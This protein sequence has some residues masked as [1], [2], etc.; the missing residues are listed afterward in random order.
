MMKKHNHR[1][2]ALLLGAFLLACLTGCGSASKKKA[3]V[4]AT[5]S[6]EDSVAQ[7]YAEKFAEELESLSGGSMQIEIHPNSELGSNKELLASCGKGDIQFLV[8][9]T[10]VQL[11]T[12]PNLAVFDLPC[13]F[14]N[15]D[16]LRKKLDDQT[17]SEMIEEVYAKEGYHYLGMADQG[18]CLLTSN[19]EIKK[20][21]SFK[22]LKLRSM[23]NSCHKA[24]WTALGSVPTKAKL[25]QTYDALKEGG[26]DAQES[27]YETI[28]A[29]KF[30]EQQTYLVETNHIP[31]LISLFCNEN[32]YNNLSEGEKFIMK[33]ASNTATEYARSMADQRIAGQKKAIEEA[34]CQIITPDDKLRE[35]IRSSTSGVYSSIRSSISARICDAYGDRY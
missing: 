21:K 1:L 10:D 4:I 11:G 5:A 30:Y 12:M 24:F 8:Q 20:V 9:S 13:V 32:F 27:S 26:L 7:I 23:D 25:S 15:L 2:L 29:R 28:A 35:E 3:W 19:K 16:D 34:G 33:E 31:D 17:F 14:D 6:P 18:F 22:D